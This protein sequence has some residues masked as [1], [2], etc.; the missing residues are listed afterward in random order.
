RLPALPIVLIEGNHDRHAGAPPREWGFECRTG[1]WP[2]AP[3]LCCHEPPASPK[4][5]V[6]AGHLHPAF[7]L[8]ERNGAGLCNPCF[9]FSRRL[10]VLPAFGTFTGTYSIKPLLGDQVYLV[11]P[12]AV[13]D[14]S[15]VVEL[16]KKKGASLPR[17]G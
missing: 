6:L 1:P 16:S 15:R 4:G 7:H 11:G 17:R 8:R 5:F 9:H 10:G 12:G 14:V 2:L 13:I 3:F